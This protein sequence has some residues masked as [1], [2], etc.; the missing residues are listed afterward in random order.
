MGSVQDE[1]AGLEASAEFHRRKADW[2][3]S[4]SS[5]LLWLAVATLVLNVVVRVIIWI[6]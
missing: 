4:L 5:R 2:L 1:I 6:A 3:G